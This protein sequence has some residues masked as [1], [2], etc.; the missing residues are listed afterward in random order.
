MLKRLFDH[1]LSHSGLRMVTMR[2]MV[3]DFKQ[4]NPFPGK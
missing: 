3:D 2:E 4:P 1:M